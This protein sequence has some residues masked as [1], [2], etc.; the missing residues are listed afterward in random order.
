VTDRAAEAAAELYGLEPAEFTG[1]RGELA[2]AARTAGDA[3]GAKRITALRKPTRA[4]WLV[5]R[6]VRSHP[7]VPGQLAS[8]SEGLRAAA[9]SRDGQRL[10]ELSAER[11]SLV[12]SLTGQALASASVTDPPAALSEDVSA[13]LSAAIADPSVAAELAAGMLTRAVHWAGFGEFEPG[14]GPVPV[15][16]PRPAR[17]PAPA[18]PL[19]AAEEENH[20]RQ[21]VQE[22][23]RAVANASIVTA[24][25]AAEEDRLESAVRDLEDR[26]TTARA[27]LAEARLRARRAEAAERKATGALDRLRGA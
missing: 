25:A 4:A 23:E 6:L 18:T 7:E 12:D 1:R 21:R 5:N 3:D 17:V 11:S 24:S 15:P 20:R 27:E 13:T 16:V 14:S 2:K 22:A 10:R 19:R 8:L 26:V 9:S